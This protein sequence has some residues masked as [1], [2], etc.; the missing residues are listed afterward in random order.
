MLQLSKGLWAGMINSQFLEPIES[1]HPLLVKYR[2]WWQKYEPKERWGLYY[3]A[4]I[5]FGEPLVEG[6]RR[7]GKNL[8]PDSFVSAMETLKDWRGIGLPVTFSPT[9]RQGG[10]HVYFSQVLPD[11][12]Y[13][14]LSDWI[15]I[16][17]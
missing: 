11:A 8:T 17:K 14:K 2:S 16:T 9:E 7:A 12:S 6:L 13:K 1:D 3:V 4:G 10:K 5:L 15:Q